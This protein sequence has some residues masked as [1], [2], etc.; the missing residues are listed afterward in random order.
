M[1][2]KEK[3][4]EN[5]SGILKRIE[6]LGNRSRKFFGFNSKE[7]ELFEGISHHCL[8]SKKKNMREREK[9]ENTSLPNAKKKRNGLILFLD[10]SN[11]FLD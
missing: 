10:T 2:C 4:S 1:L 5:S 6:K 8:R 11:I 7:K 9:A 3:D